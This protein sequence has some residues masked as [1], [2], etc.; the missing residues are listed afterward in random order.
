MM[1]GI[2]GWALW[3]TR[4]AQDQALWVARDAQGRRADAMRYTDQAPIRLTR[5]G[6]GSALRM[7]RGET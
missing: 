3:M 6:R 2:E 5:D 4:D 1:Y 7:T